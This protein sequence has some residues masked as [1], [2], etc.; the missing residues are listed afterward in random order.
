MPRRKRPSNTSGSE[1]WLRVAVNDAS[2]FTNEKI[3][4]AFGWHEQEMI[5]WLSPIKSDEYAEY[6]DV[7]FLQRLGI[8]EIV[9]PLHSFWPP[10]GPRWDGL[11]RTSSCKFLLVEA[12]AYIEEGVDFGSRA[13]DNS[14]KM[15]AD[16][17]EQSK[18]AYGANA[19]S[20]WESP[21]YQYANRLAH[22]HF[23][24]SNN[25]IDAH[26]VF[27]YFANAPDVRLPCTSE[28]WEGARRL[29]EKCLGLGNHAYSN[30]I[31]TVVVDVP[32]MRKS[33]ILDN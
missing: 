9:M 26:L 23:L 10:S 15:I 29:T 20:N 12:K 31:A 14:R 16:A 17:L 32:E 11:A 21:F 25:R 13:G 18:L 24:V 1:H 27:M 30:R 6:Y 28:Q 3:R 2:T 33:C 4:S 7:Q 19:D 8:K 22:L 5:E